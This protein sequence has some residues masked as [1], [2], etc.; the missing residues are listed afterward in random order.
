MS[1]IHTSALWHN[2][3]TILFEAAGTRMATPIF[4]SAEE[5]GR[6]VGQGL[7]KQ[8]N[9][10]TINY[11]SPW[12]G[13]WWRL[14]DIVEYA[15]WSAIGLLEAG[16]KHK[17]KYLLNMYRMARNSIEKGKSDAPYAYV[18]PHT[19]KDPNTVAKMINI[20]IGRRDRA[21]PSSGLLPIAKQRISGRDLCRF[22][23][24]SLPSIHN[25]YPW[26]RKSIRTDDSTRAVRRN[27]P[28]I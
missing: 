15:Y 7:G 26:A 8:G 5:L 10:Q 19:Q 27:G 23:V 17:D 25:R 14:R 4:Q 3:P 24:P 21:P 9:N 18:I 2:V 13:G 6:S 28:L 11:P 1:A 22:D 12:P 16:A 20:L